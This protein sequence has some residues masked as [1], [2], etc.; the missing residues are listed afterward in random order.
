MAECV[1]CGNT[2]YVDTAPCSVCRSEQK[3]ALFSLIDFGYL[4]PAEA[5]EVDR[6][7]RWVVL[8]IILN[9][10]AVALAYYLIATWN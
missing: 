4:Y 10:F 3:R 9:I 6:V 8:G 1:N 2:A 5:K 7:I